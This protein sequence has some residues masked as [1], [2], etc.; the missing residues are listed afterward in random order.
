MWWN[1]IKFNVSE[2]KVWAR[3]VCGMNDNNNNDNETAISAAAAA[4]AA[5]AFIAIYV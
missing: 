4:A 2:S 1:V 5:A 3:F